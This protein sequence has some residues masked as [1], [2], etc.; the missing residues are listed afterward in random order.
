MVVINQ[1]FGIGDAIFSMTAIKSLGVEILWPVLPHYVEGL[2]RAYP[3]I[4]FINW[5]DLKIDYN[6]KDRYQEKDMIVI[7]L[8]FQD[9][10]L[11]DCMK[12]KY[13]YFGFDWR[14]WKMSGMYK[15]YVKPEYELYKLL[16]PTKEPY[17]LIWETFQCDFNGVH[18]IT[19][20]DNGL[21]NIYH[22]HIDGFS[23]FD[24]SILIEE[25]TTIHAVSSSNIYLFELLDLRAKEIKLY[26]R[27]PQEK[28]HENYSYILRSH[29]YVLE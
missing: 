24:W 21:K 19:P 18:R 20:P 13:S 7:P 25:A 6:R 14:N 2:K 22:S 15:R 28:T 27:L 23:L 12:N 5:E 4:A 11:K 16:N 1:Y 9:K 10:P 29:P 3:E 8:R 26:L 17:N